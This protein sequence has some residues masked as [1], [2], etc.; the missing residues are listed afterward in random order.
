MNKSTWARIKYNRS[1][2][3]RILLED[4]QK[5]VSELTILDEEPM[6]VDVDL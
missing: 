3:P 5:A 2:I 1:D 6:K 4:Y